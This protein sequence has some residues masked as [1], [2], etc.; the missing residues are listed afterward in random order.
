MTTARFDLVLT[1][2]TAGTAKGISDQTKDALFKK[3]RIEKNKPKLAGSV[4]RAQTDQSETSFSLTI[5]EISEAYGEVISSA[6]LLLERLKERLKDLTLKIDPNENPA[7]ADAIGSVFQ[8]ENSKITYAMYLAALR[9][10]KDISIEL[11]G[12]ESVSI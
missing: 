2:A 11:G 10:D 5:G 8:N 6:N 12:M 7:L 1:I 9:L 3:P 4:Q